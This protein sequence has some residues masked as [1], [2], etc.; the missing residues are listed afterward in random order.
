MSVVF[1]PTDTV[2]YGS[3]NDSVGLVVSPAPLTVTANNAARAY[4]QDN[5]VFTGALSGLQGVDNIGV[6]YVCAASPASPPG[7]YPIVP[8]LD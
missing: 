2:D 6:E 3:V 5:P 8:V 1:T 7:A 4:G